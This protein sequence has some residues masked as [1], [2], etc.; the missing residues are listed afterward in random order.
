[1]T[2]GI[3]QSSISCYWSSVFVAYGVIAM[4]SNNYTFFTLIAYLILTE[5]LF[6]PV[7]VITWNFIRGPV[8]GMVSDW[9]LNFKFFAIVLINVFTILGAKQLYKTWQYFEYPT[10][11]DKV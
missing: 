7:F 3:W 4:D 10:I 2:D 1:M 9:L 8:E 6:F 5:A 11:V